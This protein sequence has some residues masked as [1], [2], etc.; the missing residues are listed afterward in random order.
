MHIG[1]IWFSELLKMKVNWSTLRLLTLLR[2]SII[3]VDYI[4][5][6]HDERWIHSYIRLSGGFE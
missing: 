5:M 3:T 6:K 1:L 4:E 2:D